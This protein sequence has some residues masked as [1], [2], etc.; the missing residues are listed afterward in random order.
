MMPTVYR[1]KD[2]PWPGGRGV[3]DWTRGRFVRVAVIESAGVALDRR[4][5]AI[6]TTRTGST[7]EQCAMYG[8]QHRPRKGD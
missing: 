8:G 6:V 5:H 3:Y 7:A 4:A 2:E 1:S